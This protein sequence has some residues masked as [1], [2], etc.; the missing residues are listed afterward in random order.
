MPEPD[1]AVPEDAPKVSE[2][3]GAAARAIR[4]K[5]RAS[6]SG[7]MSRLKGGRARGDR[8]DPTVTLH[9]ITRVYPEKGVEYRD[10]ISKVPFSEL[11]ERAVHITGRK[12]EYA[13]V[14]ME[15]NYPSYADP[16]AERD[17]SGDFIAPHNRADAFGYYMYL[18]DERISKAE[19]D[20]GTIHREKKPFDWRMLAV[21]GVVI[22]VVIY[23]VPR[24]MEA[25]S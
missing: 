17:D 1:P 4:S 15:P 20:L 19:H 10:D 23:M 14:D 21:I 24:L 6:L 2:A 5:A 9:V 13:L 8:R 7:L 11:P 25:A 22:C 16:D 12:R 3:V 18:I